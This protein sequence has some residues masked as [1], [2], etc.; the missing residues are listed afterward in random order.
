VLSHPSFSSLGTPT[1]II[2]NERQRL[3]ERFLAS[4]RSFFE[5]LDG[6]VFNKRKTTLRL[7]VQRKFTVFFSSSSR[8]A[9][10]TRRSGVAASSRSSNSVQPLRLVANAH[11]LDVQCHNVQPYDEERIERPAGDGRNADHLGT[12]WTM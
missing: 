11:R 12:S 9:F 8:C 7:D 1:L 4:G 5:Q 3:E 6:I 10:A 2:E